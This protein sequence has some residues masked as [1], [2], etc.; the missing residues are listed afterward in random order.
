M[1]LSL[2]YKARDKPF[3]EAFFFYTV[4]SLPCQ[5]CSN[6][7]L[8]DRKNAFPLNKAKETRFIFREKWKKKRYTDDIIQIKRCDTCQQAFMGVALYIFLPASY[9]ENVI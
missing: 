8:K 5:F 4:L 9:E 6:P 2:K 1:Q 7:Q 3:F